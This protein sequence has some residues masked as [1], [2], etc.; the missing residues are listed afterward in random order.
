MHA[1]T[2]PIQACFA[3]RHVPCEHRALCS[4]SG[5]QNAHVESEG[6]EPLSTGPL[7]RACQ[8]VRW[9]RNGVGKWAPQK[10]W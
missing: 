9:G 8:G 4:D 3:S 5:L 7:N 1:H 10:M 6:E 2:A